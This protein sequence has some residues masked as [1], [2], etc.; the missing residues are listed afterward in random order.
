MQTWLVEREALA[1]QRDEH[2]SEHADQC[3]AHAR[4]AG[5]QEYRT[6]YSRDNHQQSDCNT[7]LSQ[8]NLPYSELV[9]AV[10]GYE[11]LLGL[12]RRCLAALRG[13][14]SIIERLPLPRT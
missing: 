12:R 1:S 10:T 11:Y 2:A 6:G 9:L 4:S 14:G 5:S 7:T 3:T 13:L 8:D